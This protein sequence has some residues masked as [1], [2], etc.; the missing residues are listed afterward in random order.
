[1]P[2][3][4][5]VETVREGLKLYLEGQTIAKVDIFTSKLRWM[6]P[7]HLAQ[8]LSEQ[9]ITAISRR[10]KYLLLE[11]SNGNYLIIHLGMSGSFAIHSTHGFPH[12][13]SEKR[14][15][16]DHVV[17]HLLNGTV[18]TYNDPRKFGM[19]DLVAGHNLRTYPR[20]KLLGMEPLGNGFDEVYLTKQLKKRTSP[21][22]NVLLDQ[23]VIAGI[24]NIY[25]SESLWRAGISP[26]Q[27]ANRVTHKKVGNLV[28][29]I[30]EVLNDAIKSGGSTLRN[31]RSIAGNLGYFQHQFSVYDQEGKPCKT[32]NCT[33]LIKRIVQTGRST[34]YCPSCQK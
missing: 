9:T 2:E 19:M 17:F 5:E 24:G 7:T 30:R 6:L 10:G 3:L 12:Y 8:S 32:P 26:M 34:F 27:K 21:V 18:I 15:Q 29:A 16:H 1:M 13:I 25:A 28:I 14:H 4:P 20:L 22:K 31:Y 33:S 23:K 11:V